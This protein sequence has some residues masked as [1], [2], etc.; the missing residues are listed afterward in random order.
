MA[1]SQATQD[2]FMGGNASVLPQ[3][4]DQE[5]EQQQQQTSTDPAHSADKSSSSS[6]SSSLSP[7]SS[8]SSSP[9]SED[10]DFEIFLHLKR[11]YDSNLT[12]I[13]HQTISLT[14]DPEIE[15]FERVRAEWIKRSNNLPATLRQLREE[16]ARAIAERDSLSLSLAE[17][18]EHL[19]P[20]LR[21]L[22][23]AESQLAA[24]RED[25]EHLALSLR[26]LKERRERE[27]L[28]ST[29][30]HAA[31]KERITR[32]EREIEI[33]RQT[34]TDRRIAEVRN[35][36]LTLEREREIGER[37][38]VEQVEDL[39]RRLRRELKEKNEAEEWAMLFM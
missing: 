31:Q 3:S 9:S 21:K 7:P 16:K 6:S 18:K 19:I 34:E 29:E 37:K 36:V 30:E 14:R 10:R 22:K 27:T 12:A 15:L 20:A 28:E 17:V 1:A 8:S 39:T 11:V 26:V 24:E 25:N 35:C 13:R 38:L 2:A 23:L 32:A 5:E 33:V 4:G